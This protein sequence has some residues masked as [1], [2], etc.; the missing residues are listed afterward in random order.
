LL[1][2]LSVLASPPFP[3]LV[4]KGNH[5]PSTQREERARER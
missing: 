5:L 2:P 3:E 4:K 1:V